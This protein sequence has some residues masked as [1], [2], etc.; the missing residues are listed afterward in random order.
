MCTPRQKRPSHQVSQ[1]TYVECKGCHAAKCF[2]HILE[3]HVHASEAILSAASD[4]GGIAWHDFHQ[5]A[6][7]RQIRVASEQFPI[8]TPPTLRTRLVYYA[9]NFA[10]LLP[11]KSWMTSGFY[12]VQMASPF[13]LPS[14][15][16]VYTHLRNGALPILDPL[17]ENPF[18]DPQLSHRSRVHSQ[19]LALL[20]LS[21]LQRPSLAQSAKLR[22][23]RV[24]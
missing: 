15:H 3:G 17:Q 4:P 11:V 7:N 9:E 8:G 20:L 1:G 14:S 5:K 6:K 10:H 24:S 13:V 19:E 12:D 21:S 18:Q 22:M 16:V 23:H 2:M